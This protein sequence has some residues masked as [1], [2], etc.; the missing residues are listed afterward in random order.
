MGWDWLGPVLGSAL[1]GG[2]AYLGTKSAG[3]NALEA[4]QMMSAANTADADAALEAAQ[5]WATAGPGGTADFDP[6]A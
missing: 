2:L 6:D 4:A 1:G 3:E 5:P